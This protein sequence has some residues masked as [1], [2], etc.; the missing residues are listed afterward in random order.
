[1][2]KNNFLFVLKKSLVQKYE[3]EQTCRKSTKEEKLV[4][5]Y[6]W[7]NKTTVQKI[8][9]K[10]TILRSSEKEGVRNKTET[11]QY[12]KEQENVSTKCTRATGKLKKGVTL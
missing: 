7:S 6:T 3:V 2:C 9:Y 5:M 4:H 11:G 10:T 12:L 8:Y 1:M